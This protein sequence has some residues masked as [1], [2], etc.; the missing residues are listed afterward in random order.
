MS[1]PEQWR[2]IAGFEGHYQVSTYGRV[3]GLNR[4][5]SW[6]RRIQGRILRISVIHSGEVVSLTKNALPF[7]RAIQRLVAIAF[8][9]NPHGLPRVMHIDRNKEHNA[10]GNLKWASMSDIVRHR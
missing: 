3:K 1:V 4:F 10:V 2:D 8:I 6:G 5:D 7:N 9:P